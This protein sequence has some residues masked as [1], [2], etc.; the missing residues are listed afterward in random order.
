MAIMCPGAEAK[1]KA[2]SCIILEHVFEVNQI[3]AASTARFPR[4]DADLVVYQ[5]YDKVSKSG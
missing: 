5:E 2:V 3:V 4:L 1:P